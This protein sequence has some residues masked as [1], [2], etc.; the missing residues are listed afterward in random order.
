MQ[1]FEKHELFCENM[2][3]LTKFVNNWPNPSG[4]TGIGGVAEVRICNLEY[5]CMQRTSRRNES[6]SSYYNKVQQQ[7]SCT[8]DGKFLY[9]Y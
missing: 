1:N 5:N 2:N 6:S 7:E 8:T 4:N 3:F 9:M